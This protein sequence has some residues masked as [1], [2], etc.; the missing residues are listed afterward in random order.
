MEHAATDLFSALEHSAW[1]A[2]I[3]QSVWL[4]P[5]ANIGHVV[6]LVLFAG[7][8][9]VMDLRLLGA[10]AATRPADVVGPAR[11]AALVAFLLMVLTGSILFTA[12]ASHLAANPVFQLKVA[13]IA[14]GLLNVLAF[15]TVAARSLRA[16]PAGA[17]LPTAARAT[18]MVSLALWLAVAACGRSIAYF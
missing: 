17:R 15:Q 7:A 1:G 2:T 18:A 16:L 5:F 11:T 12:E 10:F 8:L 14:L 4:Y 3:R 13:L 9:A 6:A